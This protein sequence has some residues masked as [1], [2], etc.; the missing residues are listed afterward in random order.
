MHLWRYT[1]SQTSNPTLSMLRVVYP[2]LQ[3]QC[4]LLPGF[5]IPQFLNRS[6]IRLVTYL[7]PE[8]KC[9]GSK[10]GE[11]RRPGSGA[12]STWATRCFLTIAN[13]MF[14]LYFSCYLKRTQQIFNKLTKKREHL[15][16]VYVSKNTNQCMFSSLVLLVYEA[17][18]YFCV[19]PIHIHLG[20]FLFL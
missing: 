14:S 8:G 7:T 16:K 5:Q 12:L 11:P 3:V 1:S 9:R 4:H 2:H 20:F 15:F 18:H 19:H 6:L 13:N 10:I 17:V